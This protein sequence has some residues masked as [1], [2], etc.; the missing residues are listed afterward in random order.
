MRHLSSHPLSRLRAE[1]ES[2]LLYFS[3][4]ARIPP[5]RFFS[6]DAPPRG[7]SLR[8]RSFPKRSRVRGCAHGNK[9]LNMRKTFDLF[10]IKEYLVYVKQKLRNPPFLPCRAAV[11]GYI[12][13]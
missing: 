4:S 11:C 9:I 1:W 5:P 3:V 8:P 2:R 10:K 12:G 6:S 7:A 13:S